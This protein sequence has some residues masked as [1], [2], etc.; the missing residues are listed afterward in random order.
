MVKSAS[1]Y[2]NLTDSHEAGKSIGDQISEALGGDS[3]DALIIFAS[4]T[5]DYAQLLP[6]ITEACSPGTLV[7]CSS[8]GEF[9]T[10]SLGVHAVSALAL[11]APEME[12]NA[13][14]G[15]GLRADTEAAA[16]EVVGS[17]RGVSDNNYLYRSALVL[18]DALAGRADRLVEE[19]T[20]LTAGTYQFFGGGAG[21]DGQFSHTYVFYGAEAHSDAVV[22]LEILSNKPIGIGVSH[23]WLPA[24]PAMRVTA[25]EGMNLVSVNAA[26][27][28][29]LFE[30]HAQQTGQQID[31]ANPLPFFLHNVIGLKDEQGYHLRVPLHV[32]DDG[33]IMCAA[34]VPSGATMHVMGTQGTSASEAAAQAA[35][36]AMRQLQDHKPQVALFFDCVATRLRMGKEFGA[37]LATLQKEIG[38]AEYVGCNTYGQI[39]RAEGEFSGFHNCTAVV[40]LF[41]E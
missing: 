40:C 33:S 14:L 23:G 28:L 36:S 37:E 35:R 24:T 13:S 17:F 10:G 12:F 22:A 41:P 16:A 19:L 11:K 8:A 38:Q 6:A 27:A 2:S 34:D 18:T 5:Y 9:V 21:D 20:L 30:E 29:E 39:A 1:A 4:P 26:P 15:R 25:S 3:P 31:P 32:G 7:G